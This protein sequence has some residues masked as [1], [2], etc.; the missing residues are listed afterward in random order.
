VV[1]ES[2]SGSPAVIGICLTLVTVGT[3]ALGRTPT[4]AQLVAS[5]N[6]EQAAPRPTG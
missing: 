3:I 1:G 5:G 4:I 6:P 2:W